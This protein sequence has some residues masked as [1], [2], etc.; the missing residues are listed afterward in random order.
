MTDVTSHVDVTHVGFV[1][2]TI[3]PHLANVLRGQL[4]ALFCSELQHQPHQYVES[5]VQVKRFV[6]WLK[7]VVGLFDA[8]M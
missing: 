2:K 7:P 1:K 3:C 8:P 6:L 4:H 5:Y